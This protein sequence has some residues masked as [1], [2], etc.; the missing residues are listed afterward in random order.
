MVAVA[1]TKT[2]TVDAD[3]PV[4]LQYNYY[5]DACTSARATHRVWID[6]YRIEEDGT[7][8][9]LDILLCGHHLNRHADA[10]EEAG[11]ELEE[12]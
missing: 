10:L 6:R 7:A 9:S 1:P 3:H 12:L 5:C 8:K 2:E 11:Y 4:L